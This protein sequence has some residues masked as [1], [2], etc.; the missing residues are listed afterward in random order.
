[1]GQETYT[2]TNLPWCSIHKNVKLFFCTFFAKITLLKMTQIF[3]V[4]CFFWHLR[5][6]YK[7]FRL[8]NFCKISFLINKTLR[9][10]KS[11]KKFVTIYQNQNPNYPILET[12]ID[13]I[14]NCFLEASN[15]LFKKNFNKNFLIFQIDQ[16]FEITIL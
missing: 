10:W 1:M 9:F 11:W 12:G 6:F 16:K 15:L 3:T 13:K 14:S 4:I 8:F 7:V 5:L 2:Q